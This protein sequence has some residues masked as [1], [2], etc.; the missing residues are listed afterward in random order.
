ML[1]QL[2]QY[3]G[4]DTQVAEPDWCERENLLNL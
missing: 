4:V 2:L 3:V 1:H